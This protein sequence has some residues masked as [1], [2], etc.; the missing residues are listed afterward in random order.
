MAKNISLKSIWN[1]K[2]PRCRKGDIFEKP[3]KI[4]DPLAMPKNCAICGQA[5]EPEPGFYFGAMFI[6]YIIGGWLL[7][8]PALVLVFGFHWSVEAAMI[9]TILFAA[10]V[11]LKLMRGARSLWLHLVVKYDPGFDKTLLPLSKN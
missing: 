4:T 6:S 10:V 5:T 2:C 11:Y 1:E 3:F 7:L 9:F 8:I